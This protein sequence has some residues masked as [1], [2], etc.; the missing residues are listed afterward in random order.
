MP[1]PA[2]RHPPLTVLVVR[3]RGTRGISRTQL[4]GGDRVGIM[5]VDT[6]RDG[7]LAGV[8]VVVMHPED[9]ERGLEWSRRRR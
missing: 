5:T 6:T 9:L 3:L 4:G 1:S 8:E 2:A 7:G